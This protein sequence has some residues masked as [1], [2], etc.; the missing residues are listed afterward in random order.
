M[1]PF[2]TI[3]Q[4]TLK[5]HVNS[6]H[7]DRKKFKC[8]HCAFVAQKKSDL[9]HHSA[10]HKKEWPYPCSLC[11]YRFKHKSDLMSHVKK[12]HKLDRL[13]FSC[14]K[15]DFSA[16]KQEDIKKHMIEIH[17]NIPTVVIEKLPEEI[18]QQKNGT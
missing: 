13:I 12:I 2:K 14:Q 4:K 15:C 3:C 1:C 18:V 8:S 16:A 10:C 5:S 17:G 7:R 6:R 9:E 11:T